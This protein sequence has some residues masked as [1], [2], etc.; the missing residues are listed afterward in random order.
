M[1]S[2][3]HVPGSFQEDFQDFQE[4]ATIPTMSEGKFA[5]W[6]T[7]TQV[8]EILAVSERTVTSM[9]TGDNPKIQTTAQPRPGKAPLNLY[10]PGDVERLRQERNTDKPFLMPFQE[11]VEASRNLPAIAESVGQVL[12]QPATLRIMLLEMADA[13]R[14]RRGPQ[15]YNTDQAARLLGLPKSQIERSRKSGRLP[16]RFLGGRW[17]YRREDLETFEPEWETPP[18]RKVKAAGESV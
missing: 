10:H 14:P 11:D 9:S 3:K 17:F 8:A 12:A 1:T 6:L 16:S 18:V 4:G 15:F 13:M 7:K 2:R 5:D